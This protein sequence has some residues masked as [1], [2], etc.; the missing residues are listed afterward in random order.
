MGEEERERID[1]VIAEFEKNATSIATNFVDS[2][3]EKY[4]S[5]RN[6][7][8]SEPLLYPI[9]PEWIVKHRWGSGFRSF[10][11]QKSEHYAPRRK[12]IGD[13]IYELRQFI[14][15]GASHPVALSF[16]EIAYAVKTASLESLWKK[17]H[18]RREADPEGAITAS[19]TMLETTM[20][21]ILDEMEEEYSECDDILDLYKKVSGKLNLSPG[22][23][24]EQIFKQILQGVSAVVT[25]FSSLRNKYGDAHGKGKKYVGP[26]KRHTDLTINL[27]GTICAFLIETFKAQIKR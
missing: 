2:N 13:S 16:D 9:M 3:Y 6:N 25:G 18:S 19:K 22:N 17:I 27:S 14:E 12:F 26:E 11:Q 21:Y 15:K 10:M 8:L 5:A 4:E 7:L 1:S 20:K 23:H 24:N